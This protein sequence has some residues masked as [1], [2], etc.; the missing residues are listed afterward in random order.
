MPMIED[1][2]RKSAIP[3]GCAEACARRSRVPGTHHS[4][5]PRSFSPFPPRRVVTCRG[6]QA[7]NRS[8]KM[9]PRFFPRPA[10]LEFAL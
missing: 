2:G 6:R 7:Q 3:L 5:I 10:H 1:Y 8:Q 9:L 4:D